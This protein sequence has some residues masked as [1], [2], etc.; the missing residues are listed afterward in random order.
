[1]KKRFL[2]ILPGLLFWGLSICAQ[3]NNFWYFGKNAAL[4]F[5]PA[6]G[7][8]IPTVVGN[9]RMGANEAAGSVSDAD[10]NLL[11][12]TNGVD[13]Y[14][15]N[16]QVMLNGNTIGG[17]VSAAQLQVVPQP[18]HDSIYYIFTTDA[19]EGDFQAGYRYSIVNTNRAGGL[20]EVTVKGNLL[21]PS[22]S[23]RLGAA[24]HS[25]GVDVWIIT[26]DLRSNIFRAWLLSCNGIEAQ[27]VV[28]TI[29]AIVNGGPTA[30]AG[31]IKFS[32]D[33]RLLCQTHF[34]IFDEFN[35]P[36]N[37]FQLFDFN[38]N[39]GIIS[40]ARSFTFPQTQYTHAEFSPNSQVLYVSRPYDRKMDQ[41]DLSSATQPG[42]AASRVAFSL[43]NSYYD[44]QR[45]PD[46][47]IYMSR[48]GLTL[49]TINAPNIPGA[50]CTIQQNAISVFPG[51]A[52]IGLP[53][54]INDI[55]A[56]NNPDA[57]FD[58]I[59]TD[60]CAG[61][62]QFQASSTM[63]GILSWEW[64]F[65]DGRT[66][67][68]QNPTHSFTPV[69]NNFNVKLRVR[70]SLSCGASLR[71]RIIIPAGFDIAVK[72][73]AYVKCDSGYVR[74]EN[75]TLLTNGRDGQFSWDFGDGI[76]SAEANPIHVYAQPG[77]YAVV[78]R[79]TN[80]LSCLNESFTSNVKV[81]TIDINISPD[82]T[83]TVGESIQLFAT[84]IADGTY[85]WSP[86]TALNF[87]NIGRPTAI[88]IEDITYKVL[89]KNPDGCRAED[90][91]HITVIQYEDIYVPS[92]F[93]PDDNGRNDFFKPSY[94]AAYT[95]KDFTVFNRQGQ[96]VFNTHE[97]GKA[98]DGKVSGRS[99]PVGV[100]VWQFSGT[101][102][103]GKNVSRK[104]LVTL[105]R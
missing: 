68:L 19:I 105:I 70:S 34:P 16:H 78:L 55:G 52:F 48:P 14:N 94:G 45:A 79:W 3:Q 75:T 73:N 100:Y 13:V 37:F 103:S 56:A 104:G 17:N 15:R 95:M 42:I 31:V 93:S 76:T 41:F 28:S 85:E 61:T 84:G 47:K 58:Y 36:S 24:R 38:N 9:S 43:T 64:D 91:V 74:F 18:G 33:G 54:F 77:N 60:T 21:T 25:N 71:S 86:P 87:T 26:N 69:T 66:S 4:N 46:E 39:T 59:V 8:P 49:A 98:W 2:T 65:G 82:Q 83:I 88:P 72:F 57:T 32:P 92:A 99:Q 10:G 67:T 22:C 44:L 53:S 51:S 101:D 5:N 80:A 6:A 63:P 20:G 89:L 102:R 7:S 97:R 90:S 30:G 27:P 23:E 1:M 11:F 96:V 35:R 29:G 12:Y 62:V 81:E 40:N 50:G